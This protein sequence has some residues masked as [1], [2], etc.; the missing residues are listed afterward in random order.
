MVVY[1]INRLP[2]SV[3]G[4][5]PYEK[6]YNHKPY[7]QHLKVIDCLCYAKNVTETD[8]LQSRVIASV[9]VGYFEVQK[10]YILYDVH[11][12]FFIVNRD[13]SFR[14][15]EFPFKWNNSI[16]PVFVDNL[17]GNNYEE[18][19]VLRL[20]VPNGLGINTN[21]HMENVIHTDN[22]ILTAGC[23]LSSRNTFAA[24]M[25]RVSQPTQKSYTSPQIYRPL[26]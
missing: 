24:P 19:S 3:V 12:Q 25:N 9:L 11:N 8:K 13:V 10:G 2:Y 26:S 17:T 20:T 21:H 15:D 1:I 7:I 5:S 14:E 4:S 22:V 18:I 23:P 6:L 16:K